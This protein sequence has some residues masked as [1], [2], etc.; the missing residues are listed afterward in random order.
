MAFRSPAPP[1]PVR[2]AAAG[3]FT[4]MLLPPLEA[5]LQ[6]IEGPPQTTMVVKQPRSRLGRGEENDI[7]FRSPTISRYHADI[8][9]DSDGFWIGD[10]GSSS[11][12]LVN[13]VPIVI[14]TLL[15]SGDLIGIGEYELRFVVAPVPPRPA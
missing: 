14:Q 10:L 6:V 13:S 12:V 9:R 5:K 7:V 8:I 1:S 3:E 2:R 11:G 15:N 4:L